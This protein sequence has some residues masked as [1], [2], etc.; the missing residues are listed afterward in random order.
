[1]N[2]NETITSR[3]DKTVV[4]GKLTVLNAYIR[5]QKKFQIKFLS[6]ET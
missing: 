6:H 5:K 4:K 2:A 3:K 1:M